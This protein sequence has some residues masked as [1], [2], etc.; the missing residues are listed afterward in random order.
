M[1]QAIKV[2]GLRKLYRIVSA[3]S[4]RAHDLPATWNKLEI[5]T[6]DGPVHARMY[7][8]GEADPAKP[9]IVYFHGGGWVV[10]DLDTHTPFCQLLSE[11]SGCT[12]ISVAY[13]LAPE[14]PFPAA[15]RDCL[16]ATSWIADHAGDFGRS[17]H[18]LVLAGDSAGAYLATATC[19]EIEGAARNAIAA[20]VIIYPVTTHYR[21]GF[22]S[23]TERAKGQTLTTSLMTWFWDLYLGSCDPDSAAAARAFPLH[24]DNL[25]TLPPTFLVTAEFDPLRDEGAAYA[26]SLRQAGVSLYY[27]HFD[28]AAHGFACSDGYNEHLQGMMEDLLP[29]LAKVS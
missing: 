21:D 23:Y 12:V 18:R 14:H 6:P 27:R 16:A 19:L 4:W 15:G 24:S 11:R 26:D 20:Q 3:R 2:W 8:H 17:S 9:L 29:W 28:R 7:R 22:A 1:W 25:G 13:R 5:P 10:G